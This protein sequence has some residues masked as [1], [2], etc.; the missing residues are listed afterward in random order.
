M[1]TIDIELF[2]YDTTPNSID[3]TE[4]FYRDK[5]NY[6]YEALCKFYNQENITNDSNN[7]FYFLT[8]YSMKKDNVDRS[9]TSFY[10]RREDKTN[11][12]FQHTIHIFGKYLYTNTFLSKYL[13][14][15]KSHRHSVIGIKRIERQ[16]DNKTNIVFYITLKKEPYV[17]KPQPKYKLIEL[18]YC[19]ICLDI[20]RQTFKNSPYKCNHKEVCIDCFN[21]LVGMK[22][23]CPLCRSKYKTNRNN[24][25]S[26]V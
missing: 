10:F 2:E 15:Y 22:N 8:T 18:P 9:Y 17:E 12:M 11:T 25:Y 20:D 24:I 19:C 26:I 13:R 4:L 21:K 3:I 6:E 16:V 14:K 23:E 5:R 1:E 7:W